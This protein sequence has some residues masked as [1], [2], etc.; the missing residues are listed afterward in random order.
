M[1]NMDIDDL[2]PRI[3]P[4]AKKDLSPLSV[5]EL[6][7]YIAELEAEIERVKANIAAKENHR[8]GA[9]SFFKK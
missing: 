7:N 4:Q 3:K 6:R 8:L 5:E 2:E 1:K 9:E